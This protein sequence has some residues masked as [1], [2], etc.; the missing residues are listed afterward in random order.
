MKY[1]LYVL[2][3]TLTVFGTVSAGRLFYIESRGES[4]IRRVDPVIK[5]NVPEWYEYSR[6][7]ENGRDRCYVFVGR[8]DSGEISALTSNCRFFQ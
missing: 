8:D 4:L 2:L 3:L 7:G 1:T 6:P 5:E